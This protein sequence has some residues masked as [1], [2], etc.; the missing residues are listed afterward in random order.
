MMYGNKIELR[1]VGRVTQYETDAG[2]V[3]VDLDKAALVRLLDELVKWERAQQRPMTKVIEGA[4]AVINRIESERAPP[5]VVIDNEL[6]AEPKRSDWQ[7][8]LDS[9]C[10]PK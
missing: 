3:D 1:D 8:V 5:Y 6:R 10:P 9:I 7:D 2:R 4:Q